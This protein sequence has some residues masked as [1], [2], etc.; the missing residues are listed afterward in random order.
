MR[1][2]DADDAEW[3]QRSGYS[4]RVIVPPGV[5]SPGMFLQQVAFKTGDTMPPHFHNRTTEVFIPTSSG[6]MVINGERVPLIPGTVLVCEPGD[7]HGIPLVKK[8][9]DILVMK[10]DAEEDDNEWLE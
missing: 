9:F 1:L 5:L 10:L 7:I 8:D 4:K 2:F 6:E 3:L